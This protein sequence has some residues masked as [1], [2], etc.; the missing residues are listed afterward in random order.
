MNKYQQMKKAKEEE[1]E[2][3]LV[4]DTTKTHTLSNPTVGKK[5]DWIQQGPDLVCKSCESLHGIR[6]GVHKR[7]KGFDENNNMIIENV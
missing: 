6:I 4:E 2:K 5:H 3:L 1:E 7:L